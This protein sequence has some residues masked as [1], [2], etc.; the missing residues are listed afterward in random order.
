MTFKYCNFLAFIKRVKLLSKT[1]L[2]Y[3]KIFLTSSEENESNEN[4][5][6]TVIVKGSVKFEKRRVRC[7][8]NLVW[9]LLILAVQY[10]TITI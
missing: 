5:M 10:G 6:S 4:C 8:V 3:F 1:I 7:Y 2:L 9:Y